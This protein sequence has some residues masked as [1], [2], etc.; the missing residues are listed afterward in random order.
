MPP[1]EIKPEQLKPGQLKPEPIPAP[2]EPPSQPPTEP[3]LPPERAAA[4]EGES[5]AL[6]APNMIGDLLA[7]SCGMRTVTYFVQGP[8]IFVPGTPGTPG[9]PGIPGL[10]FPNPSAPGGVTIIRPPVAGTPATPG[11]PGFTIPANPVPVTTTIFVPSESHS[12]KIADNESAR[13]Q[14][15][16]INTFNFFN[17]VEG[18][19]NARIGSTVGTVNF[20]REIIGFEKTFFD[21]YASIGMRLPFDLLDL[22]GIN[23]TSADAGDLSI[24]LKGILFQDTE[25]NY[26]IS[27]GLVVTV[28][29][30]PVALAGPGFALDVFHNTQ[31]QPFL[32]FLWTRDNFFLQGFLSVD[33]PTDSNDVT[34]MFNDW[35]VGYFVYRD[36]DNDRFLTG[37]APTV[38]V[39]VNDPLNHRNPSNDCL[40][41]LPDW[42][43]ITG[44][45]TFEFN[46]RST[47]AIGVSAPVTGPKPYA[48]EAIS[49][50]NIR[51]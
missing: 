46:R 17:F 43:D 36:R 18:Q 6:A 2:K 28:P 29:T 16:L 5:V 34:F 38:E 37:V 27:G 20:Y 15:R 23:M 49:Q 21:G 12:F 42:V 30:G 24:I 44:G 51:F 41:G 35:G 22:N 39:H 40:F 47:L 25:M 13:P 10:G 7:P 19:N 50:L 11:T 4:F 1:L 31:L 9:T 8:A 48:M 3:L 33:V 32:G 26:L 14:D 45:I